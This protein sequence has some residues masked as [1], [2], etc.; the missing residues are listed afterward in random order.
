MI[1]DPKTNEWN[2]LKDQFEVLM[3]NEIEREDSFEKF[4]DGTLIK[5]A[6]KTKLWMSFLR[7]LAARALARIRVGT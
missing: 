5:N 7:K 4:L 1:G 6:I 2:L 3:Q